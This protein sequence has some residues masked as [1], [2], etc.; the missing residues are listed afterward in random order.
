MIYIYVRYMV[1]SIHL[2]TFPA[3]GPSL[4]SQT[5]IMSICSH[6][7][8]AYAVSAIILDKQPTR[9]PRPKYYYEQMES[10]MNIY[11]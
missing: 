8:I 4:L 7:N 11:A 10:I 6:A 9:L 5:A 1:P 2:A 3:R